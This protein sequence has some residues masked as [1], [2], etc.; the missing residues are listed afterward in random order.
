MDAPESRPDVQTEHD[1]WF[2]PGLVPGSERLR[3]VA[4]RVAGAVEN[5][6]AKRALKPQEREKLH[7]VVARVVAN[8]VHHYLT[9][10]SGGIVVPRSKKVLG[11]KPTRY[12]PF[13]FPEPFPKWLDALAAL[14]F[15]RQ[16]RG[17][18]ANWPEKARRTTIRADAKLIRLI[19]EHQV[20]FEDIRDEGPTE[21]ITLSRS[22]AGYWDDDPYERRIDYDDNETTQQYRSELQGINRWLAQADIQF[23]A[24]L[25]H[26]PVDVYARRLYRRF[27]QGS[28]D[29]GGRLFGGFWQSLPNEPKRYPYSVRLK[30]LRIDGEPVAGLDYSQ[31]NPILCYSVV[32]AE[33]PLPDAYTLPELEPYRDGVKR[34]FNAML[35]HRPVTK[36]PQRTSEE[37]EKETTP[38]P[39]GIKCA[40]VVATILDCHP[41][42]HAILCS[43][44]MGH[45]LQF[46]ESQIMMRVLRCCR[47]RNI[48]ALPVF[49]C[50]VV[51]ASAEAAV[52]EIMQREF[53]AVS[54]LKISVKRELS[55]PAD[56]NE[57]TGVRRV[58][59]QHLHRR[60]EA[61]K[62]S[63]L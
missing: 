5:Y 34:V 20:S 43:G 25:Y 42:L 38:Y 26:K 41:K 4:A 45:H 46:L 40:R 9:G 50:V 47:E 63:G 52:R 17:V 11:A 32:E 54:G 10:N 23:D 33:P 2:D 24:G 22:K 57:R 49:D 37:V 61:L 56:D 30:G 44:N 21:V 27:T 31:L 53:K 3:Q 7:D 60:V 19:K 1:P 28:F 62:W 51:K 14:G 16:R 15:A 59:L 55:E 8:L 6:R 58:L 18:Y 35:F 36:F 13:S 48:V 39:K 12:Q 29:S